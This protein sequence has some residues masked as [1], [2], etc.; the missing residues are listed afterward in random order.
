MVRMVKIGNKTKCLKDWCQ[1]LGRNYKAVY[2]RIS[3]GM[4][5]VEALRVSPKVAPTKPITANLARLKAQ[6]TDEQKA[7]AMQEWKR[8]AQACR[9]QGVIHELW[10]RLTDILF[11]VATSPE[12][13][14]ADVALY[15]EMEPPFHQY[16]Q[17][18]SPRDLAA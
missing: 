15:R 18:T 3:R 16:D 17:Y 5:P 1:E 14:L 12:G 6:P 7:W 11:E 2:G 9:E 8:R 10:P 13:A 4:D